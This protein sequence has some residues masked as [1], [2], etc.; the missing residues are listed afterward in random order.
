MSGVSDLRVGVGTRL[1]FDIIR[2]SGAVLVSGDGGGFLVIGDD[3]GPLENG[4]L[5]AVLDNG[6]FGGSLVKGDGG[7]FLVNG[8]KGGF[9]NVGDPG[10]AVIVVLNGT[11][12]NLFNFASLNMSLPAS[13]K[14]IFLPPS[15]ADCSNA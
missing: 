3:G 12:K 10:D 5:G 7:G 14:T 15:I 6:E 9:E 2:V 13:D 11:F 1:D 8:D 4:E